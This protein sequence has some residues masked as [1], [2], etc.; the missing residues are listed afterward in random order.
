MKKEALS[1]SFYKL[2]ARVPKN[3]SSYA[4]V[5]ETQLVPCNDTGCIGIY[6]HRYV[7]T[8]T[9]FPAVEI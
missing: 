4:K 2:T 5:H 6:I 9:L 3:G 1:N 7:Y 8:M